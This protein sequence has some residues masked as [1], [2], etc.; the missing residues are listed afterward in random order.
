MAASLPPLVFAPRPL[1]LYRTVD[2]EIGASTAAREMLT[3]VDQN[4]KLPEYGSEFVCCFPFNCSFCPCGLKTDPDGERKVQHCGKYSRCIGCCGILPCICGCGIF[5]G[6]YCD[7]KSSECSKE[8]KVL[9]K[10][11][12]EREKNIEKREAKAKEKVMLRQEQATAAKSGAPTRDAYGEGLACANCLG[13][14]ECLSA[15]GSLS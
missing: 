14:A 2:E 11:N 5:K 4:C 10:K 15:L 8:N 7:Q 6:C 12:A 9:A 1:T 3:R 13:C